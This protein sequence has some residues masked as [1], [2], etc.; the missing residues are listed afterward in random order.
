LGQIIDG[1]S[2]M[3]DSVVLGMDQLIPDKP[4]Q[5]KSSLDVREDGCKK[6]EKAACSQDGRRL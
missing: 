3:E 5:V 4:M 6:P 2:F 1:S